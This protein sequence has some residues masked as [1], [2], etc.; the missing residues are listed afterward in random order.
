MRHHKQA[1]RK[2]RLLNGQGSKLFLSLGAL[3]LLAA[4]GGAVVPAQKVTISYAEPTPVPVPADGDE[5]GVAPSNPDAASQP[6]AQDPTEEPAPTDEAAGDP[7]EEPAPTEE[8]ATDEPTAE[9]TEELTEEPAST[10]EV[11]EEPTAEATLEETVEPTATPPPPSVEPEEAPALVAPRVDTDEAYVQYVNVGRCDAVEWNG[12]NWEADRAYEPGSWGYVGPD[13]NGR[14]PDLTMIFNR[15]GEQESDN[16]QYLHRCRAFGEQFG[17]RFDV[18]N[19]SYL[20]RLRFVEPVR[21]PGK[22]Q[23]NVSIEDHQMLTN[24]DIAAEAGGVGIA[25]ERAFEVTVGDNQLAIDFAGISSMTDP[26]AIV[27]AIAVLDTTVSGPPPIP[28]ELPTP[29]PTEEP[30]QALSE[31]AAG[32]AFEAESGDIQ[33]PFR[34]RSGYIYQRRDMS[35]SEDIAKSGRATYTFNVDTAGNYII[36]MMVNAPDD[37]QNSLYVAVDAQ[38]TAPLNIWDVDVTD[39]FEQRVVSW[40]GSGTFD[41]NEFDPAVF[42]LTAGEH[43]L[44]LAGREENT[45]VDRIWFEPIDGTPGEEPTTPAPTE[46]PTEEPTVEPGSYAQSVNAGQCGAVSWAG[47]DWAADQAYTAGSWGH[48]GSSFNPV[49]ASL[50]DPVRAI[51]GALYGDSGQELH[52]CQVYGESFGYHFDVPAG[53]YA[54]HLRFADPVHE[55]GERM[56]DVIVEGGLLLNDF[57]VAAEAGGPNIAIERSFTVSVTD[58]QLNIDFAG[59]Q[60]GSN[61]PNA[62]VQAVRVATLDVDQGSITPPEPTEEPTE[63]PTA[64]PTNPAP[65]AEPTEEPT[66]PAPTEEPTAEP[67]T[68]PTDEPVSGLAF[69][70]ESGDIR[71]PFTVASGYLFQEIETSSSDGV[72]QGGRAAYTFN[73]DTAGSY[74][75]R[76]LVNAPNSGQNSFYVAVDAQPTNPANIWDVDVTDGF[77]QRTVSWRGSGGVSNNEFDP[78]VFALTAGQ[79]T[80]AIVGREANTQIDRIWLEQVDSSTPGEE[81]STPEPTV[82]PTAEPTEEPTDPPDE[83]PYYA[84]YVN[85]GRCSE[86]AWGGILWAADQP[87]SGNDWG[88]VGPDYNARLPGYDLIVDDSG[89]PMS[90]SAQYLHRCRAFGEN[91]GYR[92]DVPSGDYIIRL[93]FVEPLRSPGQRLFDVNIEGYTALDDFDI[94]AEAGGTARIVERAFLV[95][96]TDG[97]LGIQ[98]EGSPAASDRNA[99]VQAIA[100][101]SADGT[102]PPPPTDEPGEPTE[103]PTVE[104]TT[105]A[106]TEEPTEEPTTP[107]PTEEPTTPPPTA[108]PQPTQGAPSGAD[109]LVTFQTINDWNNYGNLPFSGWSSILNDRRHSTDQVASVSNPDPSGL[110]ANNVLEFSIQ[111]TSG[112]LSKVEGI[113]IFN[114]TGA[115]VI[116]WVAWYYIPEGTEIISSNLGWE[117]M[118]IMQFEANAS[119]GI[120]GPMWA[121]N[122]MNNN[123]SSFAMN[124][125]HYPNMSQYD[126]FNTSVTIP[127][128]EWFQLRA[129]VSYR[130]TTSFQL[131][132]NGQSVPLRNS[133]GQTPTD[134]PVDADSHHA[135]L[136]D[137]YTSGLRQDGQNSGSIYVG[138]VSL[139]QVE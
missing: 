74:V 137:L 39:G 99:V 81:T 95:S 119:D 121:V 1:Q 10:E 42:S 53:D 103:E 40:R 47:F 60:P 59:D 55:A 43:T 100:V 19:G 17:Y 15:S 70:A 82:E 63:E 58:G 31:Q 26:R 56:F 91:F 136:V 45:R 51:T 101:T 115:E 65:T 50:V 46:E 69:E 138:P 90:E 80:L 93:R 77:E 113:V 8:G 124:V 21:E 54:I 98:F 79:H 97:Q 89:Q 48:V 94:A 32:L 109:H 133:R 7:T 4:I 9:P 29:E 83:T 85:A 27:Q 72:S 52:R 104:P 35:A 112:E 13:Y 24:F 131:W 114:G 30:P 12:A 64:E 23:F 87:Y 34:V 132:L 84:T 18:P 14:S 38:P 75:V 78:I 16:A 92:F 86:V 102:E 36:R 105:P 128:G 2:M 67:T 120:K 33:S 62:L 106:P 5:A 134:K 49:D 122:L 96:V 22:R 88:Y 110:N 61:D 3:A 123:N 68:D 20:V 135:A 130:A 71:S 37:G 116:D 76:A 57:D 108:T 44:V 25:I 11:T 66:T 118:L 6:P 129:R 127:K 28:A 41:N 126:L 111:T 125:L 117:Q 139:Y 73:V 107:A